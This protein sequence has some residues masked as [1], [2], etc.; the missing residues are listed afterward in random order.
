MHNKL[1][2]ADGVIAVTG[3]RNISSEYFDASSNFSLQI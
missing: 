1:I 2:I 3:G